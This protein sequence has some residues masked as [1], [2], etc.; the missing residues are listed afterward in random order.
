MK[1]FNITKR[2]IVFFLLG[3]LTFLLI[4]TIYNWSDSKKAFMNG[5]NGYKA[6]VKK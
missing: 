5:W 2:E 6:E 4:E 3:L 1:K